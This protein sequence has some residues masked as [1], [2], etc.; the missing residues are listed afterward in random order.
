MTGVPASGMPDG[1]VTGCAQLGPGRTVS[2]G[3]H[4]GKAMRF[5]LDF[6]TVSGYVEDRLKEAA[7]KGSDFFQPVDMVSWLSQ[8]CDMVN[9]CGEPVH[10]VSCSSEA[11]D[12]A[13]YCASIP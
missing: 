4:C 10:M 7:G 9:C 5:A 6:H 13:S 2:G 1:T 11:A 8:G 3:P 12:R